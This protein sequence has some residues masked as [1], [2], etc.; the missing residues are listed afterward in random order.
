MSELFVKSAKHVTSHILRITFS[1]GTERNVDFAPFIFSN[2]HPDYEKY[3]DERVFLTF[4]LIDGN[5]NW[6]DY[7]MIFPVTDLYSGKL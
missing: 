6:D 1:D 5:L 2:G 7:R 3:K 4:E